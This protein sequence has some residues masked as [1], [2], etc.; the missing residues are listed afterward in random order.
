MK[1]KIAI[2]LTNNQLSNHFGKADHFKI[3]EIGNGAIQN[4]TKRKAPPHEHG[5]LPQW[6]ADEG[7]TNIISGGI[8]QKAIARFQELNI[9]FVCGI[10]S[11]EPEI[12]VQKFLDNILASG[13]NLC[14]H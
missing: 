5:K 3:F 14:D 7:I 2:P 10:E 6:I 9:K 4:I 13:L 8:G 11:E 12:L 1:Q